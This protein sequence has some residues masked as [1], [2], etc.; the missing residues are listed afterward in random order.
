MASSSVCPYSQLCFE[1]QFRSHRM[2]DEATR[3]EKVS[4]F[5][6]STCLL[7]YVNVSVLIKF[8]QKTG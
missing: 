1:G 7:H 4:A 8:S 3:N 5:S 6:A 2:E